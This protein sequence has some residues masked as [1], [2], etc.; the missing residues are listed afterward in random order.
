VNMMLVGMLAA[1]VVIL[2]LTHLATKPQPSLVNMGSA[3]R[4]APRQA[5]DAPVSY[6]SAAGGSY[7]PES[8]LSSVLGLDKHPATLAKINNT[9]RTVAADAGIP[10]SMVGAPDATATDPGGTEGTAPLKSPASLLSIIEQEGVS[11]G[12]PALKAII[13]ELTTKISDLSSAEIGD[14]NAFLDKLVDN[15]VAGAVKATPS[16]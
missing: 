12:V 16:A 13:S 5:K 15:V 10:T 14:L 7:E 6:M 9:L 1:C 4:A 8:W 11:V 2:A 3:F